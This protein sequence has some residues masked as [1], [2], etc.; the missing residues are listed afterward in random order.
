MDID[1]CSCSGKNLEKLVKPAVLLLLCREELHGYELVR[2]L[3][4][5]LASGHMKP[6]SSAVYHALRSLEAQELVVSSWVV[7]A[8]GP[9]RR[10][11]RITPDGE[12]CTRRWFETLR[13]YH[14][15]LGSFLR[16]ADRILE[17]DTEV[18]AP[19]AGAASP[20]ACSCS[21]DPDGD[22]PG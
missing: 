7:S 16:L 2:R 21:C 11:Y 4:T 17:T 1:A 10:C 14:A 5:L 3:G 20:C 22:R 6:D 18:A 9:A 12:L 19:D 8:G 15:A 13:E